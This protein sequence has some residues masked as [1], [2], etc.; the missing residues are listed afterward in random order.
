MKS[1]F[2][3]K[4][5]RRSS[6][7]LFSFR[8]KR[9]PNAHFPKAA[10]ADCSCGSDSNETRS[11]ASRLLH[12]RKHPRLAKPSKAVVVPYL[13]KVGPGFRVMV[14]TCPVKVAEPAWRQKTTRSQQ[15]RQGADSAG[16][17]GSSNLGRSPSMIF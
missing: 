11:R 15:K 9:R 16:A 1:S 4:N 12:T 10:E 2:G 3:S 14:Y 13:S 8:K 17:V 5:Q 6:N 7:N